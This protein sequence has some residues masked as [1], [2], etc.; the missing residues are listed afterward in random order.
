MAL[1]QGG[2]VQPGNIASSMGAWQADGQFNFESLYNKS[3]YLKEVNRRFANL[4]AAPKPKFQSKTYTRKVNLEKNKL[5]S[6]NHRLG[7]DKLK[8]S[9][10]DRNGKLLNILYKTKSP[11]TVEITPPVNADSVLLTFT[12]LDESIQNPVKSTVDVAVRAL[13]M[14]RRASITYRES[15]SMVLPG[16]APE[17]GFLGQQTINNMQA[18]GYGFVFGFTDDNTI[19]TIKDNGWLSKNDSIVTPATRAFTSDLDIKVSIE[20]ITGFKIDLSA[21]RYEAKNTTINYT[22]DVM[23]KTFTGSYN[24]TMMALATSFKPTGNAHSN[25]NSR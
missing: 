7:S 18:P 14:L 2:G 4:T 19:K 15:N 24:I 16:F 8:F 3:K 12:T 21:K 20:P 13:M 6:I 10:I 22:F 1:I 9:A 17:P 25:Y 11:T 23:P 5:I